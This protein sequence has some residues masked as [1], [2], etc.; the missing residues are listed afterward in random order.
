MYFLSEKKV[1]FG[2]FEIDDW[3][4]CLKH[5]CDPVV[6]SLGHEAR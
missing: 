4:P 1:I 3:V 6:D 5:Q 2:A